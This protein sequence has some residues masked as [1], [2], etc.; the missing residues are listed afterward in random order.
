[1]D[2]TWYGNEGFTEVSDL[3]IKPGSWPRVIVARGPRQSA[4]VFD[5]GERFTRHGEF[6][7]YIYTAEQL[8]L[9]VS[10]G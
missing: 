1:M 7:G 2:P 9:V 4:K 8:S 10:D 3:G 6:A 5:R